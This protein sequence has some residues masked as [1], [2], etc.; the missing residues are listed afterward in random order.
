M[1]SLKATT[2]LATAWFV[3]DLDD[4]EEQEEVRKYGGRVLLCDGTFAQKVNMAYKAVHDGELVLQAP[5]VLLV[6]DDVRFRP[7]WLDH[8][9]DVARRYKPAVVGTNDLANPR[10]IR[11]EHA[12]HMLIRDRK[13]TR[14]N[15][16]H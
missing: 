2:G 3:C 8:A 5:W 16:S 10:T 1:V 12:T 7:S 11:G 13:S 14:L 6:G 15:S 4:I 9:Q